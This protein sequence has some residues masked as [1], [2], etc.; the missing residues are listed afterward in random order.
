MAVLVN[1]SPRFIR[2]YRKLPL[3]IQTDFDNNIALFIKNPTHPSLQTHK[4]EGRRHGCF[5]FRLRDGYRVLF[6]YSGSNI[7]NL[8]DVGP[9]DIYRR[10]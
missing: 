6:E 9:H 10:R 4:L 8:L 1:N 7:V 2:A 3:H 5:A